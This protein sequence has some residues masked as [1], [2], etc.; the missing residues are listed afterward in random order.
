MRGLARLCAAMRPRVHGADRV[1]VCGAQWKGRC[2]RGGSGTL[3]KEVRCRDRSQ[4]ALA[5][6][7]DVSRTSGTGTSDYQLNVNAVV[8]EGLRKVLA[9]TVECGYRTTL[10]VGALERKPPKG[11]WACNEDTV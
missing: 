7:R 4:W 1:A 3:G 2:L 11:A 6:R 10:V 5:A 9:S 8:V